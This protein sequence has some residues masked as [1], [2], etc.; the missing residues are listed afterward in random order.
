MITLKSNDISIL[1]L[2]RQGYNLA[3]QVIFDVSDWMEEY[4]PGDNNGSIEVI[5]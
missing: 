2:G 3:R 5:R 1:S 4:C